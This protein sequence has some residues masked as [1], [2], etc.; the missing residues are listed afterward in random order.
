MVNKAELETTISLVNAINQYRQWIG[1]NPL[2]TSEAAAKMI[3]IGAPIFAAVARTMR[4]SKI[5]TIGFPKIEWFE[6]IAASGWDGSQDTDMTWVLNQ[7]ALLEAATM[8]LQWYVE[9]FHGDIA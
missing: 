5:A 9:G 2:F 1:I 4:E 8:G 3:E 7:G 6:R